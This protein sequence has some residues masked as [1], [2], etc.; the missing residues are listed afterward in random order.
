[1]SACGLHGQLV[2]HAFRSMQTL[3]AMSGDER[4]RR[5]IWA[6]ACSRLFDPIPLRTLLAMP[7]RIVDDAKAWLIELACVLWEAYNPDWLWNDPP[8]F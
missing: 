6:S 8:Q 7:C 1:M 3:G 2:A 4:W 5:S